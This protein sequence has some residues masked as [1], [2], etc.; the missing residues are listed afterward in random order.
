V[1]V[2]SFLNILGIAIVTLFINTYGI[3]YFGLNVFPDWAKPANIT[4]S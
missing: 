3:A 1:K 4:A 2:G